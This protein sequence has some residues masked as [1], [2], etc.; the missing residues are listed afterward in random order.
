MLLVGL[1]QLNQFM[2]I[3]YVDVGSMQGCAAQGALVLEDLALWTLPER[4]LGA[5]PQSPDESRPSERCSLSGCRSVAHVKNPS[6]P[7]KNCLES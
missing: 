2:Y 5:T 7:L 1:L 6:K 3:L 4:L